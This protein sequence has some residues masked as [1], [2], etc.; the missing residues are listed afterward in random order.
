MVCIGKNTASCSNNTQFLPVLCAPRCVRAV[1]T[2]PQPFAGWGK[3]D[4][5]HGSGLCR[6][7]M[8]CN[9][10]SLGCGAHVVFHVGSFCAWGGLACAGHTL[11]LAIHTV[12]TR[13]RRVQG[14]GGG[15]WSTE[16]VAVTDLALYCGT[17][18]LKNPRGARFNELL[19]TAMQGGPGG[20]GTCWMLV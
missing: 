17:L 12:F 3:R 5:L 6:R 19:H 18:G 4:G 1:P 10:L 13:G 16:E 8:L 2:R 14:E 9:G 15:Q 7:V 20:W 11:P